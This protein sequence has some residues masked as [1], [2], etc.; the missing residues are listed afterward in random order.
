MQAPGLIRCL[1]AL[2][3]LASSSLMAAQPAEDAV[4]AAVEAF[5]KA[6]IAKD[7]PQM[8]ALIADQIV[9]A[10]S[11]GRTETKA[12]Y[13]TDATDPRAVWKFINLT[14]QT[15]QIAGNAAVVRHIYTGESEREGGKVQSTKI[16]VMM[17]WQ[18]QDGRWW[19]IARQAYRL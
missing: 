2:V 15:I 10:H 5:R 1:L 7:R 13:I 12:E 3:L 6:V 17:V 8:E 14:N 19:L 11:D 9:Y 4:A 16:G 18:N